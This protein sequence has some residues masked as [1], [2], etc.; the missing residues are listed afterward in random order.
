MNDIG[1][2]MRR[3]R[4]LRG[5]R[6]EDVADRLGVHLATVQKWEK[7]TSDIILSRLEAWGAALG[8]AIDVVV[9]KDVP[10]TPDLTTRQRALLHRVFAIVGQLSDAQCDAV[11]G[12]LNVL[13]PQ[14]EQANDVPER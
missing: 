11:V 12:L 4:T 9:R 10:P 8:V 6:L 1:Q 5:L 3:I 7:G 2:E 14:A 13:V